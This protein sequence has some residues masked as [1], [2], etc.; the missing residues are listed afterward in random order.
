[1]GRTH[2]ISDRAVEGPFLLI[3]VAGRHI[4]TGADW[5]PIA[6]YRRARSRRES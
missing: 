2:E 3:D 5:I 4:W 6:A 1:M